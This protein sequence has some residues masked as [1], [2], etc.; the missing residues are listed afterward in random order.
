ME[1]TIEKYL[2]EHPDQMPRDELVMETDTQTLRFLRGEALRLGHQSDILMNSIRQL[3]GDTLISLSVPDLQLLEAKL[4]KGLSC[5]KSKKVDLMTKAS[6]NTSFTPILVEVD[7]L[8]A[9][10]REDII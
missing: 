10:P 8:K 9:L 2:N 3:M 7:I 6:G 1:G 4:E 5:I